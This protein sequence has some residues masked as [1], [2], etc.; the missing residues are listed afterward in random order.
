MENLLYLFLGLEITFFGIIS[1]FLYSI[2]RVLLEGYMFKINIFGMMAIGLL[3]FIPASII[4][5]VI[6]FVITAVFCPICFGF[7][8]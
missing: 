5:I 2:I 7:I 1:F 4:T 8:P 6:M 3:S